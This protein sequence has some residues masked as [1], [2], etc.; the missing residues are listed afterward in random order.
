MFHLKYRKSESSAAAADRRRRIVGDSVAT[1][2]DSSLFGRFLTSFGDQQ[3]GLTTNGSIFD[4]NS[5]LL[6]IE[7]P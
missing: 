5:I 2:S 6:N 7:R 1:F 4:S 3:T